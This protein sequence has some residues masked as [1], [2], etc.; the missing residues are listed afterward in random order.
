MMLN[1]IRKLGLRL[2][3]LV[4]FEP[5]ERNMMIRLVMFLLLTALILTG[6]SAIVQR[7]WQVTHTS[8]PASKVT[9]AKPAEILAAMYAWAT[10]TPEREVPTLGKRIS[11]QAPWLPTTSIEQASV[12]IAKFVSDVVHSDAVTGAAAWV[13]HTY[14]GAV[15]S[16]ASWAG[17]GA[18][19]PTPVALQTPAPR[20][21]AVAAAPAPVPAKVAPAPAPVAPPPAMVAQSVVPT[22]TVP[23]PSPSAPPVPARVVQATPTLP[24]PPPVVAKPAQQAEL[25]KS[26]S[27]SVTQK[28][29]AIG[30]LAGTG[31]SLLIGPAELAAWVTGA[32]VLPATV[33][34]VGTVIGAAL[35]TGCAT[36]ALVAPAIAK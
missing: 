8:N 13:T 34:V 3:P 14:N 5:V 12:G 2:N 32:V 28:G 7:G 1:L 23:T 4:Y 9:Q 10:L 36:G 30:G 20:P 29:C 18:A 25:W 24:L 17:I 16:V 22:L 26:G 11:D 33:R 35:V 21:V 6:A 27:W 31:A 19:V 15:S